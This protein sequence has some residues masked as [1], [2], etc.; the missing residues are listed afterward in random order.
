MNIMKLSSNFFTS[1]GLTPYKHI[2]ITE[3]EIPGFYAIPPSQ[4]DMATNLYKSGMYLYANSAKRVASPSDFSL[5]LGAYLYT[6]SSTPTGYRSDGGKTS[7]WTSTFGR[8]NTY[9]YMVTQGNMVSE[10]TNTVEAYGFRPMI[11]INYTSSAS[12][13]SLS[14]L[15]ERFPTAISYEDG[16]YLIH[17]YAGL[18]YLSAYTN[19]MIA[20][21]NILKEKIALACDI[22]C[23][24]AWMK[25]IKNFSGVFDGRG[26]AIKDLNIIGEYSGFIGESYGGE[27]RNLYLLDVNIEGTVAGAIMGKAYGASS[28][29]I[30]Y[31]YPPTSFA[32]SVIQNVYFEGGS[33][34][35]NMISGGVAGLVG[36]GYG[37]PALSVYETAVILDGISASDNP[38][39][40]AF[41]GMGVN[42]TI[43]VLIYPSSSSKVKRSGTFYME[44]SYVWSW[45]TPYAYSSNC[46]ATFKNA[47]HT[48][49]TVDAIKFGGPYGNYDWGSEDV[50]DVWVRYGFSADLGPTLRWL[51]LPEVSQSLPAQTKTELLSKLTN[52]FNVFEVTEDTLESLPGLPGSVGPDIRDLVPPGTIIPVPPPSIRPT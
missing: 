50:S 32:S 28:D 23:G 40:A 9:A 8:N 4:Q 39:T 2:L 13:S 34:N 6:S 41:V 42:D 37:L 35:G 1:A 46:G 25:A 24:G 27:V 47:Y 44:N 11:T 49:L 18:T 16:V 33:V 22:D 10:A 31:R 19:Y 20:G 15:A 12:Y 52:G 17:S 29:N 30:M 26:H 45:T 51:L 14:S 3:S 7:C 43:E 21:E 5:S 38:L 48:Y 36:G